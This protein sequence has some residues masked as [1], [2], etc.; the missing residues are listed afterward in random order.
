MVASTVKQAGLR[1]EVGVQDRR[2]VRGVLLGAGL[3]AENSEREHRG[4][5]RAEVGDDGVDERAM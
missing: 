4:A 2:G 1:D 5:D 3:I